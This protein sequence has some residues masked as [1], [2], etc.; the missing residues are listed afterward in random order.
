[1]HT[2]FESSILS[3]IINLYNEKIMPTPVL[4]CKLST[5]ANHIVP[6]LKQINPQAEKANRITKELCQKY[7]ISLP[8]IDE[9]NT[10]TAYAFPHASLDRLVTINLWLDFLYFINDLYDRNITHIYSY[11]TKKYQN[12]LA[13]TLRII[14]DGYEP[15]IDHMFYP[16]AHE[17][18]RRF[19]EIA[20]PGWIERFRT[21]T[22]KHLQS[23]Q[24]DA[25]DILEDNGVISVEK[26]IKLR[27][28]DSG[29]ESM[30]S[31]I[32]VALDML[33]PDQV[34]NHPQLQRLIQ[35]AIRFASFSN[36]IFSYEKEV[37]HLGSRFNL[38][39]VFMEVYG[40]SFDAAVHKAILLVNREA[41]EFF[42]LERNLP[43]W[44]EPHWNQ[45]TRLYVS[46]LKDQIIATYHWQYSTNRYRS[47]HSPFPELRHIL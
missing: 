7:H 14:C 31:L 36:D 20:M 27:E 47:P 4:S 9:Y 25:D 38:I 17:L 5:L 18:N 29:M 30:I 6:G 35:L 1:M 12:I 40:I 23:S 32:E 34:L 15:E 21:S 41:T 46:A 11:E 45:S 16:V 13:N 37:L 2:V 3:R 19:N 28:A 43:V 10:M 8:K 39:A 33:I 22:M 44:D 26:Y 24:Y 42:E